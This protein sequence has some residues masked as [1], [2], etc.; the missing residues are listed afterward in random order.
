MGEATAPPRDEEDSTPLYGS[1]L[2]TL[3]HAKRFIGEA[4]V[5]KVKWISHQSAHRSRFYVLL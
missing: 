2:S 3:P 4:E 1:G 5:E